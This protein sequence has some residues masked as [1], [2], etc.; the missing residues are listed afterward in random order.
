MIKARATII[1]SVVGVAL[2][3]GARLYG[4]QTLSSFAATPDQRYITAP[5]DVGDIV[6]AITSTGTINATVNVEVG[7]QLSGLVAKVFCDFN[8][9]VKA[10]QPLAELDQSSLIAKVNEAEAELKVARTAAEGVRRKVQR[11]AIAVQDAKS[12]TAVLEARIAIAQASY[13]AAQAN[14]RRKQLL[15]SKG[16]GTA[17]ELDDARTRLEG[18]EAALRE[19]EAIRSAH[20]NVIAAAQADLRSAQSD[21]DTAIA[22]IPEKDALLQLAQIDLDRSVIRSPI[23]GVVVG[24]KVNQGQTLATTMEAKTVFI[25]AGDLHKMEVDA[26]VDEADIGKIKTGQ[27]A[28]F[29][30]DAFPGHQF[31]AQVRQI[32]KAPEVKQNVV[33]YTVVLS[34]DN[35]DEELMP[36]MTALVNIVVDKETSV[37]RAPLAALRYAPGGMSKDG[38]ASQGLWILG[39]DGRPRQIEVALG[40]EDSRHVEIKGTGLKPGERVI[41]GEAL[42]EASGDR[43]FGVRLG[44]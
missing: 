26:K 32:R 25:V 31:P 14:L 9:L 3:T 2:W 23:N 41:T 16:A 35:V 38:A 10:G 27:D 1:L 30:V 36:G 43:L 29:T 18:A 12:Q 5:L 28:V 34:A 6:K 20:D 39:R 7:S 15:Q 40:N 8:D 21:L 17:A 24:R 42:N 13:E 44:F 11:A 22:S 4:W 37:L 33:T 19:A